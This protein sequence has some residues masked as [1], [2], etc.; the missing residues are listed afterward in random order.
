MIMVEIGV[1]VVTF[2]RLEKLKKALQAYSEQTVQAKYIIVVNNASSDGTTEF[3]V[4][5][6]SYDEGFEKVI[7]NLPQNIGGSGGFYEGQKLAITKDADW[8]MIGDDDAY[9]EPNY[10]EGMLTYIKKNGDKCS[11]VC[12]KVLENGTYQ[13]RGRFGNPYGNFLVP[14]KQSEYKKTEFSLEHVGYLGIVIN[15]EKLIQAGL[16]ISD[17]FIWFDDVEH[18]VRL[19][20]KG[21]IVCLSNYTMIHDTENV[22]NVLSWKDYYGM[23]NL[24]DMMKK[25]YRYHFFVWVIFMIFK[26]VLCPLKGKSFKEVRLRFVGIIDGV[27][28]N[29]GINDT[30]KPGW[31]A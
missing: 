6:K 11:V 25:H 2:N 30:Y 9:P 24:T 21:D 13:H 19:K 29:M 5:W 7:L 10:I 16:V 23:R 18:C 1:V 14:I 20:K 22:P 12:G 8:I 3:L 28:G 4:E 15:K 31:K 17:Y 26:A 27:L